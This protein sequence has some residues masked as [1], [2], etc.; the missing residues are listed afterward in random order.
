MDEWILARLKDLKIKVSNSLDNYYVMPATREIKPFLNELSTW[1]VRRSRDRI[2]DGDQD[3]LNTLYYVLSEFTILISPFVPFISEKIYEILNLRTYR[4]K[5]SVHVEIMNFRDLSLSDQEKEIL[6][7]MSEDQL[8]ISNALNLR[9]KAGISLRQPLL[10]IYSQNKIHFEEIYKD[11]LNVKFISYDKKD[12]SKFEAVPDNSL[13]LN[14]EITPE[15][16]E[17]KNVRE[18]IRKIQDMRKNL[19]LKVED[20]INVFYTSSEILKQT[21]EKNLELLTKKL[22]AVSFTQD[23]DEDSDIETREH[24]LRIEVVDKK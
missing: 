11:E 1:Y 23:E 6:I 20:K 16:E 10:E 15:L 12:Y 24:K 13:I 21:L 17:E 14:L 22:N 3:A 9:T 8:S 7:K 2:K 18:F 5:L 19:G 4:G